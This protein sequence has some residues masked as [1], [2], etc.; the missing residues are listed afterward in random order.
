MDQQAIVFVTATS[1]SHFGDLQK[2]FKY[3]LVIVT[4]LSYKYYSRR[5]VASV[6]TVHSFME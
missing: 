2:S 6:P 3:F 1:V 5:L 4:A